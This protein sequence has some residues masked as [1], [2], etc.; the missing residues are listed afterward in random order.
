MNRPG[1]IPAWG[2]EGDLRPETP[3]ERDTNKDILVKG[4]EVENSWIQTLFNICLKLPLI[5]NT[6]KGRMRKFKEKIPL[7]YHILRLLTFSHNPL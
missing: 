7:A 5:P 1:Q 3:E 4:R 2:A 6:M